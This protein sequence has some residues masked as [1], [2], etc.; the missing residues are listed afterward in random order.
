LH[1]LVPSEVEPGSLVPNLDFY[2]PRTSHGS[3]LSPAIHAVLMANVGR[4]DQALETLRMAAYIDLRDTT[5]TTAGGVHIATQGGV[6]QAVVMG[7]CGL[8]PRGDALHVDPC[9]PEEWRALDV[10]VRFR[11]KRVRVRVDSD[12]VRVTADR[13]TAVVA[14]SSAATADPRGVTFHR[15]RDG[16]RAEESRSGGPRQAENEE[17]S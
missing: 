9:L 8:R 10:R 3:S 13:P 16:W 5:S 15:D 6:W 4:P 7:F 12:T 11:G 17:E 1:H 14:G 2:E